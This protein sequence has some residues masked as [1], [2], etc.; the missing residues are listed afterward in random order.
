MKRLTRTLIRNNLIGSTRHFNCGVGLTGGVGHLSRTPIRSYYFTTSTSRLQDNH[1][2][3]NNEYQSLVFDQQQQKRSSST[4]SS[5]T[6]PPSSSST[7]TT[8]TPLIFELDMSNFENIVTKSKQPVVLVCYADWNS[9]SKQLVAAL[10]DHARKNAGSLVIGKLNVDNNRD[11]AQ[12]LQVQSLPSVF[13][14]YGG[15]VLEHFATMPTKEV[16]D[17]FIDNLLLNDESNSSR[18]IIDT[19]ESLFNSGQYKQALEVYQSL[20]HLQG[21]ETIGLRGLINCAIKENNII[22]L[23]ELI[24]YTGSSDKFKSEMNTPL[25]IQAQRV[26]ELSSEM[27]N[28]Q[29]GETVESLVEKLKQ[30]P[31]DLDTKYKLSLLYFQNEKTEL[32]MQ[33]LL[34]IIKIDKH[35]NEDQAK[36]LLFKIF[37]SMPSD[38][39][40]LKYRQRFSNI[41]FL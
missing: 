28:N 23:K 21:C 37:D 38:P 34:D 22:M 31:N 20:I 8:G 2:S 5:N 15:K 32:A 11:I 30:D 27:T 33:Q 24:E 7:P 36:N 14:L 26:V 16:L 35:Y 4:S 41:W 10:E 6:S 39:L 13:S 25:L 17:K 3:N 29:D 12:S 40:V 18:K 19:A 9:P 1:S